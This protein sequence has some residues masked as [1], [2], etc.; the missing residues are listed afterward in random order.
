VDLPAG[1]SPRELETKIVT[2]QF[3]VNLG[4]DCH[5]IPSLEQVQK[6]ENALSWTNQSNDLLKNEQLKLQ[7]KKLNDAI[8]AMGFPKGWHYNLESSGAETAA[9][10]GS[11]SEMIDLFS[12]MK[13][14]IDVIDSN[15]LPVDLPSGVK[16][17]RNGDG[18]II[19]IEMPMP[20]DLRQ[21]NPKIADLIQRNREWLQKADEK[22]QNVLKDRNLPIL[23]FADTVIPQVF[24]TDGNKISAQARLDEEGNLLD[25]V[26]PATQALS[27]PD[28]Y[29]RNGHDIN[30]LQERYSVQQV[31][32]EQSSTRLQDTSALINNAMSKLSSDQKAAFEALKTTDGTYSDAQLAFLKK[33]SEK[34]VFNAAVEHNMAA[35]APDGYVKVTQYVQAQNVPWYSPQNLIATNVGNP[36]SLDERFYK[37]GDLVGVKS[38][39]GT[40]YV[41]AKSLASKQAT[42]AATLYGE[43]A[44]NLTMDAAMLAMGGVEIGAVVAGARALRTV[45]AVNST[46]LALTA[47]K[48]SLDL[49]LGVTDPISNAYWT[50]KDSGAAA[51]TRAYIFLGNIAWGLSAQGLSRFSASYAA[52]EAKSAAELGT[53]IEKSGSAIKLT[54]RLS[55]SVM[56]WGQVPMAAQIS[57]GLADQ[58]I[59]FN[60][61]PTSP[62]LAENA[63]KNYDGL[64][65]QT[66]RS[67]QDREDGLSRGDANSIRRN[68]AVLQ[69]ALNDPE[70]SELDK[71]RILSS[72]NADSFVQILLSLKQ[73]EAVQSSALQSGA[74]SEARAADDGA[75]NYGTDSASMEKSLVDTCNDT[76]NSD[77]QALASAVLFAVKRSLAN[78]EEGA[79]IVDGI[80]TMFIKFEKDGAQC[81]EMARFAN[82]ALQKQLTASDI[83][84]VQ[85]RLDAAT[86]IL[87]ANKSFDAATKKIISQSLAESFGEA[88]PEQKIDILKQFSPEQFKQLSQDNPALAAN[89]RSDA[90]KV[91]DLGRDNF[92]SQQQAQAIEMMKQMPTLLAAA[93]SET[94]AAFQERLNWILN[95][96]SPSG[97]T[98]LKVT[99]IQAL[100][101]LG[102]R[103]NFEQLEHLFIN[104]D[105]GV[106]RA[107]ALQALK[108]LDDPELGKLV[109][110]RLGND[111]DISVE[112]FLSDL[113][114]S[115][116]AKTQDQI[117][118]LDSG[119]QILPQK[120]NEFR[121]FVADI[122]QRY[123][124][125]AKFDRISQA[126]WIAENFPLLNHDEFEK[127]AQLSVRNRHVGWFDS[128]DDSARSAVDDLASQRQ[129]QFDKLLTYATMDPA[130]VSQGLPAELHK[131][132][133]TMHQNALAV[134]STV[135]TTKGAS[136]SPAKATIWA[137]FPGGRSAG[138]QY[139]ET[140]PDWAA[141]AAKAFIETA[142][143]GR[144]QRDLSARF[145]S[146][147]LAGGPEGDARNYLLQAWSSL[148][149]GGTGMSTIPPA[150]Y[151]LFNR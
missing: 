16:T 127:Q 106:V 128:Y 9:A 89:L 130:L 83:S 110:Q 32:K 53:I 6:L 111:K 33:H 129:L 143:S 51:T 13:R 82:T 8:D 147:A 103:D 112:R 91:I 48:G 92:V 61:M 64:A 95:A 102:S 145:I 36:M 99:T 141:Q 39:G 71:M 151:H 49:G 58:I 90:M 17:I 23:A 2:G 79:A 115:I 42:Q 37:P 142:Q 97:Y 146:E 26:N 66:P 5:Q 54:D 104:D 123:P 138:I 133:Q 94:R 137:Q 86:A 131:E 118:K 60:D 56:A 75:R 114:Y 12:R 24:D 70:K 121:H 69:D 30:L 7:D 126:Q 18:S 80:N 140:S 96:D 119:S 28:G 29:V 132:I 65:E 122:E 11:A 73:R 44:L 84:D 134:L 101:Q 148:N 41:D 109:G 27:S 74:I 25:V 87:T 46:R 88:N 38:G 55:K 47:G 15:H 57:A 117:G 150:I 43:K 68:G 21:E 135:I 35:T 45:A 1:M 116:D 100:A 105:S 3:A 31:N 76:N 93:D 50:S 85:R 107:S 10:R 4:I 144:S 113:K 77:L 125:L 67:S 63:V 22:I 52:H 98:A 20:Q 136:I 59:H 19:H 72:T 78:R 139:D 62:E 149:N 124:G 14:A 34:Y 40:E 120:L 81:G 108:T